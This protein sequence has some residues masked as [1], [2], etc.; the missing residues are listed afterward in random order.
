MK[1]ARI[2]GGIDRSRP[3]EACSIDKEDLMRNLLLSAVGTLASAAIAGSALAADLPVRMPAAPVAVAPIY[4]PEW[5][6]FYLGVHGGGGWDNATFDAP[7][8]GI[9]FPGMNM[10]GGLVG[11]QAGYNWQY[12]Q[13]V[14]GLEVDYSAAD[15]SQSS[16][17]LVPGFVDPVG[18]YAKVD[19][20]ASIR[21]R[22]GW[23]WMQNLLVYGTGG[24]G[25]GHVS[26][27]A[28]VD[29]ISSSAD[30]N[31]FGWVAGAGLE[32]RLFEHLMLR[33]EYLHYGL[34]RVSFPNLVGNFNVDARNEID[35]VRGGLSYKF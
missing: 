7:N 30:E 35:V 10:S 33:A 31:A 1:T 17:V 29:G 20:L 22:I 6:G 19:Q 11:G 13:V 12:G 4:I 16:F 23:A 28:V 25:G 26:G 24:F 32:Y 5:A 14:T 18:R 27:Q 8:L 3:E 9:A 34:G 21:G 15:I 2:G